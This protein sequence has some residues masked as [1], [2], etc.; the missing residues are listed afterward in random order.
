MGFSLSALLKTYMPTGLFTRSLLI[1][2]MPVVVTQIVVAFVFMERHWSTVTQRLSRAVV[3]DIAMLTDLRMREQGGDGELLSQMAGDAFSMSVAFLPGETLPAD[4]ETPIVA[5]LHQSLSRELSQQVG[6]P[7]WIDTQTYDNYVDIRVLLPGEVMRVLA[8]R[9]RVYATN[10]HIFMIWMIGTSVILLVVSG[11]FLRN[12]IRPIQRLAKA[13]EEFGKGRD[14]PD[15]RPSGATEV[16]SAAASFIEMR[17]RIQRQ[18][19]QRT[20][21]LA[22]VSHDLR[23]PLTRLKLHMAMLPQNDD[24]EEL[25]A[26]ISEME[27]MLDDYLAFARGYQGE[28][29]AEAA[30]APFLNQ[31]HHDAERRWPNVQVRL[32][33]TPD[34]NVSMKQNALRRC[35]TN[36]VNNACNHAALVHVT[37]Q[38][39]SAQDKVEIIVDDNGDGIPADKLEEVFRPFYRLDD[40]RNAQ[41]GGTGLGLAIARDVARGHGGDIVLSKSAMGGLRATISLPV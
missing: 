14:M 1:I 16:R 30:L 32:V 39:N 17:D 33:E 21:M 10:S 25:N 31:I 15:F 23:T 8:Q 28:T 13:A 29:A 26:D 18:I 27:D 9:K 36:L 2:V 41:T 11:V 38:L 35:I 34:L 12:Q 7:F 3:S 24:A 4:R 20:T 19:E 40:A 22:G 6:R 5:L 37:A